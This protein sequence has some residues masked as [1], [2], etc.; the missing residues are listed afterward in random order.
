MMPPLVRTASAIGREHVR[1]GRNNQDAVATARGGSAVVA[2][3]C[4]GCS[5]EPGSEVGAQLGSRFLA[6]WLALRMA[7]APLGLDVAETATDTLGAWMYRIAPSLDPTPDSMAGV[8]Q[9]HFLATFL[10]AVTQGD[11]ALVF[12]MGDGVVQVD[13]VNTILDS[14]PANTPEYLAYRFIRDS[15]ARPRVHFYG[16]AR[17]VALLTDGFEPLLRQDGHA[18][19]TLFDDEVV[20]HNPVHLQRRLNIMAERERFGDDATLA[21]INLEG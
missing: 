9:R 3:V 1:L 14:G 11:R 12:G 6:N 2:V 8:L 4:D 7:Q 15:R 10:A 20:W 5:A 21:L 13:D 18:I 16:T 19:D 17:R